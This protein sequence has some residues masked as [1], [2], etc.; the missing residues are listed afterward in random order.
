[1]DIIS[2][3]AENK[4]REAIEKGEL[5]NLPGQGKPLELEDLSHVPEDL[6]AGYKM[7]KNA[8]VLPEEMEIKKEIISLQKLMDCCYEEEKK[9]IIKKQLNEKI[10]RFNLLMEKRA[11]SSPA[12]SFYKD[13]IFDKFAG[14]D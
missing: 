3:I 1:M 5:K 7:L 12:L 11:V 2:L 10:L 9:N 13:K 6:R 8:G 14:K 4:I